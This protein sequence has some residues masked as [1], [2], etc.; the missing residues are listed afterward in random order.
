MFLRWFQRSWVQ[1]KTQAEVIY[2]DPSYMSTYFKKYT[3]LVKF[4]DEEDDILPAGLEPGT[5][6]LISHLHTDH[7]KMVTLRRL[8]SPATVVVT[9]K[10]IGLPDPEKE[11]LVKADTTLS[12]PNVQIEVVNA[13]NTPEGQS[14]R[15]AHKRGA[16]VG[17]IL[18]MENK[19]IYFAGDTDFIPEMAQLKQIDLAFLPIGGTFTMNP[20]EAAM[21]ARQIRPEWVIP[22]HF[23]NEDPQQFAGL[24]ANE[25]KVKVLQMG[26]TFEL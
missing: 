6:I 7:C 10:R 15:K 13:Y 18:S 11:R 17:Y 22:M 2:F 20:E 1:I 9:P 16:G 4:S 23:L 3:G 14:V 8:S 19:R 24:L 25:V 12:F 21:A 5:L 26:E